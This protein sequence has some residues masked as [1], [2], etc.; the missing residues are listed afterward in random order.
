MLRLRLRQ[1]IMSHTLCELAVQSAEKP[2]LKRTYAL[3][4]GAF[5]PLT[6]FKLDLLV[7]HQGLVGGVDVRAVDEQIIATI[8][9]C[10][11]PEAFLFV[12]KL[13]STCGQKTFSSVKR[14][15]RFYHLLTRLVSDGSFMRR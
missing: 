15:R 4:F 14:A 3:R 12:E 8:I 6:C 9:R 1:H 5:A 11:K 10:Y 2:P 13:D 7:V